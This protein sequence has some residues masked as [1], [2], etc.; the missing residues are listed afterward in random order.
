MLS[1][2]GQLL[3][4][5][6]KNFSVVAAPLTNLLSPKKVIGISQ[7]SFKTVK[8]LLTTALVHTAPNLSVPFP[9]AVDA[10]DLGAGAVLMQCSTDGVEHPIGLFSHK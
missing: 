3:Q 9:L 10:S 1:R 6:C 5:F 4:L 2:D 8:A 7:S